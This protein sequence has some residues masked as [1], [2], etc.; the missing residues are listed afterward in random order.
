MVFNILGMFKRL[1]RICCSSE[2]KSDIAERQ[3]QKHQKVSILEKAAV[4]FNDRYLTLFSSPCLVL[5]ILIEYRLFVYFT[6]F[7]VVS[8]IDAFGCPVVEH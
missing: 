3:R 5:V 7:Q 2:S 8:P 1:G 6:Y 4:K